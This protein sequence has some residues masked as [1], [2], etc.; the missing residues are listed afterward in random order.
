MKLK[1]SILCI[2]SALLVLAMVGCAPAAE[3]VSTDEPAS[4][5]TTSDASAEDTQAPAE[6][7]SDTVAQPEGF[8]SKTIEIIAPVA[9]GASADTFARAMESSADFGGNTVVLNLPGANAVTGITE[10]LAKP[11]DGHT[12]L[13]APIAGL[14]VQPAL[15]ETAYSAEDFRI[16]TA[17]G[18]LA[19]N[20]IFVPADSPYETIDDLLAAMETDDLFYASPGAGSIAQVAMMDLLEQAGVSAEHVAFAGNNEVA[21]ALLGGHVDV[22]SV[23]VSFMKSYVESGQ[24]RPLLVLADERVTST[25]PDT[26][27]AG[28]IGYEGF[29]RFMQQTFYLI[30]KDTPEAEAEWI[31]QQVYEGIRSQSYQDFL[32][33]SGTADDYSE[34]YEEEYITDLVYSASAMYQ[35]I[36]ATE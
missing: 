6:E 5:A 4:Q 25:Y 27:A 7:A 12:L 30:H 22:A 32:T 19:Y 9:A 8:P 26:P 24:F 15:T 17:C 14:C 3:E 20:G 31:K 2:L 10:A 18:P 21:T 23:A 35:E 28:E 11:A 29:E 1:R 16:L 34:P 13:I 36:F 33:S